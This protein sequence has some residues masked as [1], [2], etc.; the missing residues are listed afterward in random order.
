MDYPWKLLGFGFQQAVAGI[1][2]DDHIF[3]RSNDCIIILLGYLL[4]RLKVH[5]A[6]D[7]DIGDGVGVFAF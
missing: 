6:I 4:I 1:L 7:V 2:H 3:L 5:I